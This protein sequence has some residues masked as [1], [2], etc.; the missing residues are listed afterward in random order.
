[1]VR[2]RLWQLCLFALLVSGLRTSAAFANP[3]ATDI[4]FNVSMRGTGSA[5]IHAAIYTN[6]ANRGVTTIL[7]VHGITETASTFKPLATAIFADSTLGRVVKRVISIDLPGHGETGFPTL[8]SGVHFGDLTIEDN[9]SVVIQS[10]DVL[11]SRNLGAQVIMGHSMGGLAVQAA[12]EALLS[13]GS[14]FAK[15]GVVG[16]IL[17]AA[18]PNRGS[19]WTQPPAS[20][21]SPF[22]VTTPELG[23]YLDL[24]PAVAQQAGGWTTLTGQLASNTPTVAQITANEWVGAEP[25]TTLVELTGT[26]PPTIRPNTRQGAFALRNG[27]I[28]SVL[29][30]SQDVLA[31]AVDQDDLY[32]Y[33]TG[34]SGPLYRPIVAPDAVHSMFISNPTGLLSALC[35]GVL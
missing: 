1:M 6:P 23:T 24:P 33:L 5:T 20:N 2:I 16:A 31:P 25:I 32:L 18:V 14:S 12:Q 13:T 35:N 27:T 22:L 17:I 26:T 9:V 28:L 21:V 34:N 15:H 4:D 30:F 8:P 11:R 10:V 7:A 3:P 19:V 29:S